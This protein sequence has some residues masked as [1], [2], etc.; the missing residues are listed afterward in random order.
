MQGEC[1]HAYKDTYRDT[2]RNSQIY[3]DI[4]R[5]SCRDGNG[6]RYM[7]TYT[8]T[9][10]YGGSEIQR[11]IQRLRNTCNGRYGDIYRDARHRDTA[12]G[13]QGH[14]LQRRT[15]QRYTV[16]HTETHTYVRWSLSE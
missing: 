11:H 15:W 14:T 8:Y 2:F 4:Y 10:T 13:I 16:A 7:D 5:D 1:T 6:G 9:Y 3:R 12:R